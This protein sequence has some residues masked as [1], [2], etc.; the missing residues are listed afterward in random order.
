[1]AEFQQLD[2]GLYGTANASVTADIKIGGHQVG[3]KSTG[4]AV[5]RKINGQWKLE[6]DSITPQLGMPALDSASGN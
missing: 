1:M 3:G 5:V 2:V 6:F 4:M